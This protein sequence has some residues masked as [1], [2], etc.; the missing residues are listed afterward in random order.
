MLYGQ[1]NAPRIAVI[2]FNS[3]N[4]AKTDTQV[5]SDLFETALVNT[6]VYTVIEQKQINE[7]LQAQEY[8]LF[9]CTDEQC[10]V[11]IGQLLS[12]EHIVLGTLSLVGGKLILNAKI[13]D[14]QTGANIRADKLDAASVE[15]MTEAAELLAFKLVGLTYT[16]GGQAEIAKGFGEI[17]VETDP[18]GA[19]VYVNGVK[20]GVSPILISRAPLAVV[21]VESRKGNLYSSRE[22]NVGKSI[23]RLSMKLSLLYGNL[24]IKSE[25][26][27]VSVYLD[28]ALQGSLGSGLFENIPAGPHVVELKGEGWY[29]KAE[30]MIGAGQSMQIEAHPQA[31][32]SIGYQLAEGAVGEITGK[33]LQAVI[34]DR[35]VLTPV[36]EG[37]YIIQVTGQIYEPYKAEL[38]VRRGQTVT[39]K[40]TL[41]HTREYEYA[42]FSR[43]ISESEGILAE[44]YQIEEKDIGRAANLKAIIQASRHEFPEL[45][46]RSELLIKQAKFKQAKQK[47]SK[48]LASLTLRQRE[49]EIRIQ[50]I[51]RSRK[52]HRS[53]SWMSLGAG[54]LSLGLS[55]L[56]YYL[57]DEAYKNYLNTTITSMAIQYRKECRTWDTLTYAAWGVG[58]VGLGGSVILWA[59]KPKLDQYQA[60]LIKVQSRIHTLKEE[61]Q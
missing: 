23:T 34:R 41:Y 3:I 51:N 45:L 56:F 31:F 37:D 36:W 11:Q 35:G 54:A 5:I 27:E 30:V 6:G 2:P 21:R 59:A 20:K 24:F 18:S 53:V 13:I 57:A 40:P 50:K 17:F 39:V 33:S 10:A 1:Q 15:E 26:P 42:A 55:G 12:A 25:V 22:V 32:G 48:E 16:R 29:W 46:A 58:G 19:E 7:I 8:S 4:V 52:T 9:G 60:E 47:M 49:L 14:V 43:L 61:L 44:G 28:G 38:S